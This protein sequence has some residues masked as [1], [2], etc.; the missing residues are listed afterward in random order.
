MSILDRLL[1]WKINSELDKEL[2]DLE[3][4]LSENLI[5]VDP[6]TQFVNDLRQGLLRQFTNVEMAPSPQHKILHTGLLVTSGILGSIIVIGTGIRGLVSL[7]GV[8][9]LVISWFKQNTNGSVAPSSLS[10]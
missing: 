2:Q 9:G 3:K 6:R 8:M 10:N 5:R 1:S 4:V 7:L